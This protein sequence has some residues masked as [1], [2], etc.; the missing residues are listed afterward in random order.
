MYNQIGIKAQEFLGVCLCTLAP[1]AL[2]SATN[3]NVYFTRK[4]EYLEPYKYYY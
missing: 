2:F 3:P 1:M 4:N